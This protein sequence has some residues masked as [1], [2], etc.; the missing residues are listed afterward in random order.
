M[1]NISQKLLNL[2]TKTRFLVINVAILII[3]KA[4]LPA[5]GP[6][7]ASFVSNIIPF[8]SRGIITETNKTRVSNNLNP[9]NSNARLD[10]AASEKLSDMIN[11]SYFAHTSPQGVTP[12]FWIEKNG[13]DYSHAGENLALGFF[14]ADDTVSAWMK[15]PSHRANIINSNYTDIGV[16]TGKATINGA[17]QILIVQVFGKPAVVKTVVAQPTLAPPS[18]TVKPTTP[19]Q[20]G[21]IAGSEN[22]KTFPEQKQEPTKLQYVSTNTDIPPVLEPS[23]SATNSSLPNNLNTMYQIYLGLAL[24]LLAATIMLNGLSRKVVLS[25]AVHLSLL[26]L[27][28]VVPAATLTAKGLIF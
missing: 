3:I 21:N 9:L 19:P 1:R 23:E 18:P 2:G 8:D 15:S 4:A 17:S 10:L 25:T 24:V 12:W 7:L 5:A 22:T 11:G 27:S 28:V 20:P 26:I 14:N 6:Q 13:Y 16:A